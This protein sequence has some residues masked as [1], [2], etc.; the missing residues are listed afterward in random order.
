[1]TE[2]LTG[3]ERRWL[4]QLSSVVL[5]LTVAPLVVAALATPPRDTFGGFVYEAR[6]GVS[7]IAKTVEGVEGR[8][9]YH[10]PYTTEP[11]AASLIYAPYLALGQLD[12]VLHLPVPVLLHLT[13]LALAATLLWAAYRLCQ[14]GGA[15]LGQRRLAF[16]LVLFGAGIGL[17]GRH[18][19]ILGYHYVS[20]DTEVSGTV[21]FDALNLAPHVLLA[22]LGSAWLALI[23]SARASAGRW[24]DV[25]AVF[26]VT[27][28]ISSAYPQMA[29]MWAVIGLLVALLNWVVGSRWGVVLAGAGVAGAIPYLVYGLYLK[30][31]SPVFASWPPVGDIDIGDVFSYV[32]FAHVVMLP[33]VVIAVG[34]LA[35]RLW[36][37]RPEP[38]DQALTVL[39]V[40]AIVSA[41]L[42][43]APGLPSVM[44]RL[45]YGSFIAF[46]VLA[47]AGLWRF[48]EGRSRRMRGRLLV[49]GTALMCMSGVAAIGEGYTTP[50]LHRDD[51][52]LYF[53]LDEA[54]LLSKL[55][56]QSAAGGKVVMSS[57]L[58]GLYVPAL[59]GQT[60]YLGF[61][62]ETINTTAK[63]E[64]AAR[65][66]R[67]HDG[68]ALRVEASRLHLDYVLW[69]TYEAGYGGEDP[70][71]LA[72]WPV[73][74][75]AG[76][77]RLYRVR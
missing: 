39:A 9:L 47:S 42:M 4:L 29:V 54:R 26:I 71:P 34:D 37:R 40:W 5:L 21:G 18:Y 56:Q 27:L 22:C 13:R 43:Y 65:F 52:A 61:P 17:F 76:E 62:F 2:G 77:A 49:Y 75:A 10:D 16:I 45:Y 74:F 55:Q 66:Y 1:M 53:P 69:G 8:W 11:H 28:L 58:S 57:Y 19:Q 15:S 36:R 51:F 38:S 73:Q 63:A 48:L 46:G 35:R 44:H 72:E 41:S 12:R 23:W 14:A 3:R 67:L 7:Y 68:A 20:L 70:G 59:S 30:S 6:D 64:T 24:R 31:N 25:L 60:A 50:L 32:L 33:F